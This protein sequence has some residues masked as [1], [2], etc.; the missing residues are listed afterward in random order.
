VLA[1][2]GELAMGSVNNLVRVG[3]ISLL[4]VVLFAFAFFAVKGG[5]LFPHW[6]EYTLEFDSIQ[7]PPVGM[8][9]KLGGAVIGEVI[10]SEFKRE[11]GITE[12]TIQVDKEVELFPGTE[13]VVTSSGFISD[14]YLQPEF[15]RLNPDTGQPWEATDRLPSGETLP[16]R[17]APDPMKALAEMA[18]PMKDVLT[19]V[20]KMLSDEEL[21]GMISKLSASIDETLAGV[22]SLFGLAEGFMED[23]EGN[24]SA[25]MANMRKV[26]ESF[27]RVSQNLEEASEVV[28]KMA[29][30]PRYRDT[31]DQ[32]L[33]DLNESAATINH[34]TR[35]IDEFVSD[36]NLQQDAKDS[37]RLTKETL[38]EAKD[39]MERFQTTLDNVDTTMKSAQDVMGEAKGT[40][41]DV[42]GK[43]DQLS[44]MG[45]AV[46]VKLGF[47]VRAVDV[48]NDQS[49][50]NE[51]VYVG[52][53]NAALGYGKTYVS[54]GADNIGEDSNANFLLGYG[55]L[56][57]FSLRGGVYRGELG[58]GPAYYLPGG[59]GAELM[60]YDTEDPKIN[61]YGYVP[62]G[63]HVNV[64]LGVEDIE[65]D[66]QA[67]VGLGVEF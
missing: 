59:G 5:K 54:V 19:N 7:G 51:D 4:A 42:R 37:V 67:S 50:G 43:V 44:S 45:D 64:V 27:L 1:S 28:N 53:L 60:L 40:I 23:N 38:Q 61:G 8:E 66:A 26:S 29:S 63:D 32:V 2:C 49:L 35:Q 6:D 9:V 10:K 20:N 36:P 21:G 41:T 17:M 25:A 58:I 33:A 18:A 14:S 48:N 65:N 24:V 52:D 46:D 62:I 34:M 31:M 13:F 12:T 22:N 3:A 47:N 16:G 15:P 30:D 55:G 39:T 57:G 11:K 56:R